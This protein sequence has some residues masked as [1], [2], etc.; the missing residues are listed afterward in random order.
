MKLN[1]TYMFLGNMVILR[2]DTKKK[3]L[4]YISEK[5]NYEKLKS[6]KWHLCP[7]RDKTGKYYAIST[8]V[9]QTDY[10]TVYLHRYLMSDYD[11]QGKE[12]DHINN[13]T[14]DC[15]IKNM[16][17][18][19]RAQNGRNQIVKRSN[20]TTGFK[21]V[22]YIKRSSKYMAYIMIDHKMIYLGM[23]INKIMAA[24]AYNTAAVK[25]HGE[26]ARL[27]TI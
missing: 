10:K 26:Y 15:R 23:F 19:T 4:F 13:N 20:N 1:N 25:Y 7:R 12:I 27:N 24:M 21:G 14:H 2:I 8:N 5:S 16:R 6:L 11:I 22:S 3:T 9:I 17:V 18:T